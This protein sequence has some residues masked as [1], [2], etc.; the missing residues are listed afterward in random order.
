MNKMAGFESMEM[1]NEREP[2][3]SHQSEMTPKTVADTWNGVYEMKD[4][5]MD[6]AFG[7]AGKGGVS[8]DST[9]DH[10]QFRNYNWA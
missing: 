2:M 1:D 5:A 6:E 8:E 10:S 7:M 3:V 4:E 9:K